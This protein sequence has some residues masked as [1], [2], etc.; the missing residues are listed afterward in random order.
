MNTKSITQ[1]SHFKY[2]ENFKQNVKPSDHANEVNWN[3]KAETNSI[4]F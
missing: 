1:Q 3:H 4:I 2:G